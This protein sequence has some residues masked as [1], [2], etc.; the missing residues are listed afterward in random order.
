MTIATRKAWMRGAAVLGVAMSAFLAADLAAAQSTAPGQGTTP[1]AQGRQKLGP[2]RGLG[3][4]ML[5][6]GAAKRLGLTDAQRE[7]LKTMAQSRRDEWRALADRMRT[8]RQALREATSANPIDEAAIRQRSTE[9]AAVQA[10]IAVARA[11]AQAE[12]LQVLTP[13]Q[14]TELETMRSRLRDRIASRRQ[15]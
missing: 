8:A 5:L 1:A 3:R 6:Q 9:A 2:G 13:E 14:Q 7:Q 15:R 12:M 11:R 10:D 4:Q